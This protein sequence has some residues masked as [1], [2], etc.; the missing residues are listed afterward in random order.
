MKEER[1]DIKLIYFI[2]NKLKLSYMQNE[3]IDIAFI[4]YTKAVNTYKKENSAFGNYVYTCIKNEIYKYF[5]S[6][7]YD[8]RK[9]N[10][11]CKSLNEKIIDKN[12]EI[13]DFIKDDFDLETTID[14]KILI[15]EINRIAKE[16]LTE[17]QYAVFELYFLKNFKDV[18]IANILGVTRTRIRQLRL[19]K[20]KKLKNNKR[21]Q[22][23]KEEQWKQ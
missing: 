2:I 18:E 3:I 8:I 10:V 4:G 17:R 16:I 22:R 7:E 23:M 9:A 14:K 12:D 5:K 20:L 1:N 6:L 11:N 13:I 15:E 19:E 21:I